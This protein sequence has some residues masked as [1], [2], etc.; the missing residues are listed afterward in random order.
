ML[1][2]LFDPYLEKFRLHS[3]FA[4]TDPKNFKDSST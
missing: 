4:F 2:M 3:W 1:H